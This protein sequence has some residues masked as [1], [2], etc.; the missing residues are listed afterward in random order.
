MIVSPVEPAVPFRGSG[1]AYLVSYELR[2]FNATPLTLVPARV[3]VSSPSGEVVEKLDRRG[4]RE[5][6][7]LPGTRSGVRGAARGAAGDAVSHAE[8]R[9][10]ARR[11][12]TGSC[13]GSPLIMAVTPWSGR[14]LA[15]RREGPQGVRRPGARPAARGRTRLHRGRQLLLVERHRRAA[16]AIDNGEWL[17]QRF[18]VDWEQIDS[19]GGS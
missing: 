19:S 1:G 16:L 13:I 12:R 10:I 17:A 15:G 14:E 18:A 5:A 8:V 4:E 11:S 9:A 3:S 7:A 6:L 2:V